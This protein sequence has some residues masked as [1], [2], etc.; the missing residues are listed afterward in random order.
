MTLTGSLAWKL[1]IWFLLLSFFPIMVMAVFVRQNVSDTIENLVADETHSR[2]MLLAREIADD[3]SDTEI[4]EALTVA[5]DDT[6]KAYLLGGDGNYAANSDPSSAGRPF[7][8]DLSLNI[9]NQMLSGGSG[10][11]VDG[12]T[13]VLYAFTRTG[14]NGPTVVV[15]VD[16]SVISEPMVRIERTGLV[17][18]AASLVLV[19][20]AGGRRSGFSSAPSKR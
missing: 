4:Q 7:S 5:A 15:E 17:Q 9:R 8:E 1:T 18:L 12:S 19:S 2:V 16:P 6:H 13:S 20:T 10:V 3:A 11:V 14:D